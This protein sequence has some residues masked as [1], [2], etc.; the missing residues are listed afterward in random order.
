[1]QLCENVSGTIRYPRDE[2]KYNGYAIDGLLCFA[3]QK[4]LRM[5]AR[6]RLLS[7]AAHNDYQRW[8]ITRDTKICLPVTLSFTSIY[9]VDT[10]TISSRYLV[11]F[12]A[13]RPLQ[14]A[15]LAT[16]LRHQNSFCPKLER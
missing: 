10:I 9:V 14:L 13:L 3:N 11:I 12:P 4:I 16:T 6:I 2:E 5:R 7:A 8:Q 15:L 1:M